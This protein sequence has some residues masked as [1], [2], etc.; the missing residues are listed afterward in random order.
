MKSLF[1]ARKIMLAL[2]GLVL[3]FSASAAQFSDSIVRTATSLNVS[4]MSLIQLAK[5]FQKMSNM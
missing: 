1:S 4:G 5:T 3:A 2:V